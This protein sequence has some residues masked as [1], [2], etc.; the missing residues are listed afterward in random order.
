M[1]LAFT[2]LLFASG[3]CVSMIVGRWMWSGQYRF[4]FLPGNLCLAWIPLVFASAVYGL[5]VRGS[6]RGVLLAACAVIWFFFYPNAPYLIT[7]LV[8]LKTRE[9]VP[10]WFDLVLMMSFAWTGLFLGNLSL[11]LMQEVVRAWRGRA[12]AWSFAI[13]MLALGAVGVF[14]GRVWRWNSWEVITAPWDLASKALRNVA[15]MSAEESAL[16]AITFFAF[17]LI[18]YLMLYSLTHLHAYTDPVS[19][20]RGES[21]TTGSTGQEPA[22]AESLPAS[23]H[24]H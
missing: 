9:P 22:D 12:A 19:G 21:D 14:L 8:H 20:Q 24:D 16:F 4:G 1:Q 2:A 17:S 10:R 3:V 23:Q 15:K 5:R 13:I 7:D 6:Q 11:Y 18:T